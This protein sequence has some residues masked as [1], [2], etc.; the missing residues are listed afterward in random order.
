MLGK[1]PSPAPLPTESP[2]R[3]IT[4]ALD[5]QATRIGPGTHVKGDL[6]SDGP[7]DVAGTLDGDVKVS[8]HCRVREGARVT[9]RI[10]ADTLVVEGTVDGPSL[11]AEKIEIGAAARVTSNVRARLVAIADGAFFE[12][13][14]R[15]D[16]TGAPVTPVTFTEKRGASETRPQP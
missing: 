5:P 14:V 12:G 7:V 16:D 1:P 2:S 3:R 8:G 13:E 4:D 10:E 15:M 9:G 6:V 11:V